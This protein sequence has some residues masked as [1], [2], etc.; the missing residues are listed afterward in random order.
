[1][2]ILP[3]RKDAPDIGECI[4]CGSRDEPLDREHAIPYGL[5]GEW[6]LLRASCHDCAA[7]TTR[8]E[9]DTLRCLLPAVR[10]VLGLRTRR[11][12]RRSKL[13]PLVLES[14]GI[15][16]TV[17]V[18]VAEYPLYLPV[19]VLPPPGIIAGG[20]PK[21]DLGLRTSLQ[22]I[23]LAG[24]TFE[25]VAKRYPEVDFVGARVRFS[26]EEFARALAKM[27]YCA[28]VYTLGVAPLRS[29][30]LR[31]AI[32]EEDQCIG[33]WVGAWTGEPN[34][35]AT[36]LHGMQVRASGTDVHVF[37][38]LFAQFGTPEY[39]VVVGPADPDFARSEA[40]PW[41]D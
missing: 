22:L 32:L 35:P 34:N 12:Q 10:T 16:K 21:P 13:L 20:P 39:H 23:H 36:G 19:P 7:I 11:R 17:N 2:A 18:S 27:A 3:V 14:R 40:W 8:F 6:T 1:V 28:A 26:P 30:P 37:V 41:R 24:P 4:Y 33:H 38:R 31:R 29:S 15:Q 9:R 25:T 5:N